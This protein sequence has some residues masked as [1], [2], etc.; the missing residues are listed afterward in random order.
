MRIDRIAAGSASSIELLNNMFKKNSSSSSYQYT[1]T[2]GTAVSA[3]QDALQSQQAVVSN[4][5]EYSKLKKAIPKLSDS[6]QKELKDIL[7]TASAQIKKGTMDSET[8]SDGASKDLKKALKSNG[9]DL[10]SALDSLN[11]LYTKTSANF[12]SSSGKL[13]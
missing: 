1:D 11:S 7:T 4:I 2:S 10:S 8:L 3:I 5:S 13:R 12:I 6:E 9:V